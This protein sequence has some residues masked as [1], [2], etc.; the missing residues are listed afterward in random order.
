MQLD[1]LDIFGFPDEA[2]ARIDDRL[3]E[4][5]LIH[6]SEPFLGVHRAK[7]GLVDIRPAWMWLQDFLTLTHGAKLRQLPRRDVFG[8]AACYFQHFQ[9]LV[10]GAQADRPVA[11][12]GLDILF[13]QIRGLEDVA[14]RVNGAGVWKMSVL[15]HWFSPCLQNSCAKN[16]H[17]FLGV[18]ATSRISP[19]FPQ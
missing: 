16:P 3:F 6:A 17:I 19:R 14:V 7:G 1:I 2:E 12:F 18:F 8:R 10:V 11:I 13:P 5:L 15:C 4:P 9:P